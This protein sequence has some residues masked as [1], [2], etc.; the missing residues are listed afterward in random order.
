MKKRH[1]FF[2]VDLDQFLEIPRRGLGLEE[3][4]AYLALLVGTDKTNS[5]TAYGINSVRNYTGLSRGDAYQAVEALVQHG[6]VKKLQ[7]SRARAKTE[8]RYEIIASQTKEPLGGLEFAVIEMI[9]G[10]RQPI[11]SSEKNAA[12]RAKRKGWIEKV[13]DKWQLTEDIRRYAYLPNV[14]VRADEGLSPLAKL[15]SY[16]ELCALILAVELY[17]KQDLLKYH[18]VPPQEIR[19]HFGKLQET[20]LVEITR[21]AYSAY[22][23]SSECRLE[24]DLAGFS[25]APEDIYRGLKILQELRLVELTIFASTGAPS[26]A[27]GY[28]RLVFP[29]AVWR[30]GEMARSAPETMVSMAAY[31]IKALS[32]RDDDGLAAACTPFYS[33]RPLPFMFIHRSGFEH[34][35]G[36]GILRLVLRADTA[37]TKEWWRETQ[38]MVAQQFLVINDV[39][40]AMKLDLIEITLEKFQESIFSSDILNIFKCSSNFLKFSI[41]SRT[42]ARDDLSDEDFS[43]E[44]S[45]EHWKDDDIPF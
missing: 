37:N 31:V 2:K 22:E 33:R 18:G 7:V 36:I 25:L 42:K 34:V 35:E 4:A 27:K 10:G 12:F 3:A 14:F 24:G 15:V 38:Q 13:E 6:L 28:G 29:I 26:A 21:G 11:S 5:V 16:G 40:Q 41:N 39:A 30:S 1:G 20:P 32:S 44:N 17:F 19:L 23:L 45:A 9:K 8:P 43:E